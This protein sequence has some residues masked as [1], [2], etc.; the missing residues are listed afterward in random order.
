MP[1]VQLPVFPSGC[2]SINENLAFEK[3]DE[4]VTYFNGHLPVFTHQEK[5]L[6]SFRLFTTQLI[7]NGSATTKEIVQAFGVSLTTVKRC[8]KKYRQGGSQAMFR[9]PGRRQGTKLNAQ[10]LEQAQQLLNEGMRVPA[11]SKKMDV[12]AS[13]LHKAID[14][15]RLRIKKKMI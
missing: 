15:G 5:D 4:Q 8:L 11:I 14:H 13:T 1:Q 10:R 6:Q 7:V 9:P 3:R 2:Q 12:L